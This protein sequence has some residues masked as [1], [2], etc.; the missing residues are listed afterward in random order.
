MLVWTGV[1]RA[2]TDEIQVYDAEIAAPGQ[3]NLTWHNNYAF[4]GRSEPAF[5]G[6]IVPN[7]ELNGVPEWGVRRR[8][9]VRNGTVSELSYNAPHWE[10]IRFSGEI[11]P[12]IGW[13][14][15]FRDLIDPILDTDFTAASAT[16]ILLRQYAGP[17]T[18]AKSSP[19]RWEDYAEFGP[20]QRFLPSSQQTQTLFAVVGYG[21]AATGSNSASAR[22]SPLP[23]GLVISSC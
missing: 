13:H 10:P 22:D 16:S 14:V 6:G 12:L 17:V 2:Q 9:L 7:H 8:D 4:A 5:P 11:R 19:S 1:A 23:T 3:L 18:S 21:A 20:L 15:G